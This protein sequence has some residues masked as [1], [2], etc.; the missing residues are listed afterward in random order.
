MNN[1]SEVKE[2][3]CLQKKIPANVKINDN[4]TLILQSVINEIKEHG[5]SSMNQEVCGVLVGN[6]CWDNGAYLMIDGRIEG[7]FADHQAGSVTFTSET[8]DYIHQEL[9]E[10]FSDKKIVGWYHTHP[11]FGIF[12]SNMDFFIHENF[13]GI[14]W[15]PAYVYDPQAE[16]DGFFFW[17]EKNLERGEIA[18]IEDKPALKKSAT[19]KSGERIC[20]TITEESEKEN[21]KGRM[22]R[23]VTTVVFLLLVLL[24][25]VTFFILHKQNQQ[26]EKEKKDLEQN[27]QNEKN[28]I[29]IWKQQV[30]DEHNRQKESELRDRESSRKQILLLQK[31]VAEQKKI[32]AD[33]NAALANLSRNNSSTRQDIQKLRIK[34]NDAQKRAS[35]LEKQLAE[36]RRQNVAMRQSNTPSAAAPKEK[37]PDSPPMP[38]SKKVEGA[39]PKAKEPAPD[40]K[41]KDD[42]AWYTSKWWFWNWFK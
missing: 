25:G 4:R 31:Q 26:L 20:V 2:T 6:L 40:Q 9:S 32:I 30:Q 16:T 15:Q 18:I 33:L 37:Q 21:N 42:D 34:L 36:L 38:D 19:L 8:W 12:L 17:K 14:K 10:K 29:I 23:A 41:P 7:K 3:D 35:E 11:G 13:F 39:P 5:R 1:F 24:G 22:I 28:L 27:L